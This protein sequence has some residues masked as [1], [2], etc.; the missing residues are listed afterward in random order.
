MFL[1]FYDSKQTK[2]ML[3]KEQSLVNL[4]IQLTYWPVLASNHLDL[5]ESLNKML[6]GNI[7]NL[8][9]NVPE[10]Y[11]NDCAAIGRTSSYQ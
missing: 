4:N 6:S 10:K 9:K 1:I 5:G 11:Q 7:E 2:E 8:S 3:P